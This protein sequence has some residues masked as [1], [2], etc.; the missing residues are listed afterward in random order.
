M[1][2]YYPELMVGEHAVY[3]FDPRV[4]NAMYEEVKA[5]RGPIYINLKG[6]SD[7]EIAWLRR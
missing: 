6:L 5:G 7:A 4:I 3:T 1:G 2:K